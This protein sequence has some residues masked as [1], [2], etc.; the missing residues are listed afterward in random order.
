MK[1]ITSLPEAEA[2]RTQKIGQSLDAL[3][4]TAEWAEA[5]GFI[6]SSRAIKAAAEDLWSEYRDYVS[7]RKK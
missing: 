1:N 7:K 3:M 4:S 2:E 6:T 5:A